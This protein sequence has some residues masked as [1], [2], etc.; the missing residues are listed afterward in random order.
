MACFSIVIHIVWV[1]EICWNIIPESNTRKRK[2][3]SIINTDSQI[4]KRLTC[5]T[6]SDINRI[7]DE[8]LISDLERPS[9]VPSD[10]QPERNI[11]NQLLSQQNNLL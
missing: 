6:T 2:F 5:H 9:T 8:N 7:S 11:D 4:S 3:T 1:N 10:Q